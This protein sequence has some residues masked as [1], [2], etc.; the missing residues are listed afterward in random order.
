MRAW[1]EAIEVAEEV[2]TVPEKCPRTEDYG[3]TSQLR[4]AAV[5]ISGNIAEAIGR[6]HGKEKIKF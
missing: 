2:F 4:R 3:S 1:N 5:R 6:C